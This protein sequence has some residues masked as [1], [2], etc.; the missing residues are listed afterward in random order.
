MNPPRATVYGIPNCDTVRR[1]RAWLAAAG[2][3]HRFHDFKQAGVPPD[4]L[5]RWLAE[6]G[7]ERLVNRQGTA[8]RK[9][10][11]AARAR[12]A[13]ASGAK[14]VLTAFPSIIR[15]PVVEWADGALTVGFDEAYWAERIAS[16]A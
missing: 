4:A 13:E 9:L 15:R 16:L 2:V 7:V 10:D 8:W 6:V 12:A 14:V 1:A 11:D 5:Q 3:A